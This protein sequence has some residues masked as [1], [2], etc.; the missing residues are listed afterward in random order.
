MPPFYR[1]YQ[2]DQQFRLRIAYNQ[3]RTWSQIDCSI[4]LQFIAKGA[5]GSQS[6]TA[7]QFPVYSQKPCYVFN[8]KK[9]CFKIKCLYKHSCMKCGGMRPSAMC[10]KFEQTN[11]N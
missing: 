7:A 5:L 6:Q 4:W 10:N 9:G 3:T 2:Y 8:F 1:V 11:M